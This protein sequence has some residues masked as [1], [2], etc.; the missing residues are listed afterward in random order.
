MKTKT[1]LAAFLHHLAT[2]QI[3]SIL[4]LLGLTQGTALGRKNFH[5]RVLQAH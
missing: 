4:Q 2:K 1:D 5:V 3:C